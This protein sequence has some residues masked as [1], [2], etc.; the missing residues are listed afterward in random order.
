MKLV[1][2]TSFCEGNLSLT[3]FFFGSEEKDFQS[4]TRKK[5]KSLI[6]IQLT[7]QN[8][9]KIHTND[10]YNNYSNIVTKALALLL[11]SALNE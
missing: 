1:V 7:F 11:G 3:V 4:Q 8:S 5:K 2:E 6:L 9:L 10:L